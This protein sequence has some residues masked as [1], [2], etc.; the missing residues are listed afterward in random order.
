MNVQFYGYISA[1]LISLLGSSL[2]M[3]ALPWLL[4][5]LTD[6]VKYTAI[7]LGARLLPV[8]IS[9]FCGVKFIDRFS[10][11]TLCIMSDLVS[12]TL[13]FALPALLHHFLL[14]FLINP[15]CLE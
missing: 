4:L 8:S 5:E 13:V 6:D 9:L 12:T 10:R 14:P 7:I 1:L 2:S 11:K 3:L 15:L